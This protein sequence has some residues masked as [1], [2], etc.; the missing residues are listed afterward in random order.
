MNVQGEGRPLLDRESQIGLGLRSGR[1]DY[2]SVRLSP[3]QNRRT[4]GASR[5]RPRGLLR[6][7]AA[8]D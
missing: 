2:S 4:G 5:L 1:N 8:R 6:T 3:R 7:R